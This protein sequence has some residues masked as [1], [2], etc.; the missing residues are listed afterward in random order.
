MKFWKYW[1]LFQI[2]KIRSNRLSEAVRW[3]QVN[4]QSEE[5]DI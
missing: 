1:N 4:D 5:N 3:W 2:Y